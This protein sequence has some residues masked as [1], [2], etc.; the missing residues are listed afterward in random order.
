MI[1]ILLG[2]PGSG[3]S[4][5][6]K[7]LAKKLQIPAIS[8]GQVLR[9]AKDSKTLL[10]LEAARF[11]EKGE[12][13]P[14]RLMETLTQFRLEESDCKKGFIL[15]GAPRRV[16]EA[17]ILDD[18]LSKK[19]KKIDNVVLL[20]LTEKEVV[21]RLLLRAE[22]P[23]EKGGGRKDDNMEDIRV[24]IREYNDGIDAVKVYYRSQDK[25]AIVDG[26]GSVQE[27]YT[28][29]CALFQL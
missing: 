20:E 19:G 13:V 17:V 21:E 9:D 1:I 18:Y 8:M 14:S 6:S 23:K 11:A 22:L 7:L 28:R 2:P 27:I 10:G 4:T 25:L 3:K 29:I 26:R 16:E 24:R 12:L 5:Q 15:D